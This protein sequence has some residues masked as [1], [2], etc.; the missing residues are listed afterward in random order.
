MLAK[1]LI[2]VFLVFLALIAGENAR[3]GDLIYDDSCMSP[4][5]EPKRFS[6]LAADTVMGMT[7]E[8][9]RQYKED[10]ALISIALMPVEVAMRSP[11]AQAMLT[12]ELARLGLSLANPPVLA[13]TVLGAVG[14]STVYFILKREM[15]Q[16]EKEERNQ[17]RDE[18][19]SD[20]KQSMPIDATQSVEL[21]IQH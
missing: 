3:A 13:V 21:Q 10:L 1:N 11:Q 2:G 4:A 8:D 17:L 12:A 18:I 7:C 15:D 19:L 5:V 16:C 14:V 20:L 9:I 6:F